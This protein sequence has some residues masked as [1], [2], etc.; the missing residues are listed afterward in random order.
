M[1]AHGEEDDGRLLEAFLRGR[2]TTAEEII[3]DILGSL[4]LEACLH[5]GGLTDHDLVA[6]R[7]RLVT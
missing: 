5:A 1:N 3:V 7:S 6:L 2:G 4:D